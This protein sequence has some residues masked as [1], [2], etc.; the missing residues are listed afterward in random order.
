[1]IRISPA[2]GR[3]TV[4][5]DVDDTLVCWG[6]PTHPQAEA[7]LSVKGDDGEAVLV[8]PILSTVEALRKHHRDGDA[9][10]VWSQQG[11]AWAESV[12]L[13]LGLGGI[14]TAVSGKP[15]VAYDDLDGTYWLN[16]RL[17]GK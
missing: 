14:V 7:S 9:I 8:Q 6:A 13:A 2:P 1:M 10:V 11:A 5:C 15:D 16:H 3:K 17:P 12:V 4:F